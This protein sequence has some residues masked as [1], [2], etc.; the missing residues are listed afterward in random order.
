MLPSYIAT[1]MAV[2]DYNLCDAI[3]NNFGL[4]G[5]LADQYIRRIS[6]Y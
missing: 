3:R 4:G 2:T 1:G 5:N 6:K